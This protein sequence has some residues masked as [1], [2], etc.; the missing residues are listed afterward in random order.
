[1]NEGSPAVVAFVYRGAEDVCRVTERIGDG[2]T[3]GGTVGVGR[4][5]LGLGSVGGLEGVW[6]GRRSVFVGQEVNILRC[7]SL[8]AVQQFY[9]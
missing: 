9:S 2:G 4:E 8:L 1:M 7:I 3:A 5:R 6:R